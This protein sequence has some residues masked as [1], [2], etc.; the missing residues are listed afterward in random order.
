MDLRKR[1]SDLS[2]EVNKSH[3]VRRDA[4]SVARREVG[5]IAYRMFVTFGVMGMGSY[6][7]INDMMQREVSNAFCDVR[8][9]ISKAQEKIKNIEERYKADHKEGSKSAAQTELY[10]P[11][12]IDPALGEN[13]DAKAQIH[14]LNRGVAS[15][16][17]NMGIRV[18]C[19]GL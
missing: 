12:N 2:D 1:I 8:D 13:E 11:T 7:V 15:D 18:V 3:A 17:R 9:K 5:V 16:M 19:V 4:V 6:F 10:A 14:I